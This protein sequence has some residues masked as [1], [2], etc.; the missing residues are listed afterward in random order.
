MG[1]AVADG[2]GFEVRIDEAFIAFIYNAQKCFTMPPGRVCN[3]YKVRGLHICKQHLVGMVK[4]YMLIH[5]HHIPADAQ[6]L[7]NW[8]V[9]V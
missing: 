2:G 4:D 3:N 6:S 8:K 1:I 7:S 5:G 9:S